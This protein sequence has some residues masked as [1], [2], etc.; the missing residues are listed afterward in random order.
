MMYL[1]KD[2]SIDIRHLEQIFSDMTNSYKIYW[3]SS[4][5]E[6]VIRGNQEMQYS[7]HA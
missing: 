4:L 6:E 2:L 3:F 1:P 7:K 5:F